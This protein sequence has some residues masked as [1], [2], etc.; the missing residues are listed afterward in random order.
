VNEQFNRPLLESTSERGLGA[1]RIGV[2]S[3][4]LLYFLDIQILMESP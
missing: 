4:V 1:L 3:I 2:N